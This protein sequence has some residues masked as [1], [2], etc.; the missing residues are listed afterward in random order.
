MRNASI[1]AI[2]SEKRVLRYILAA[3]DFG[4]VMNSARSF[5]L[6]HAP[7]IVPAAAAVLKNFVPASMSGA[8]DSASKLFLTSVLPNLGQRRTTAVSSDGVNQ[9]AI[10]ALLAPEYIQ[11]RFPNSTGIQSKCALGHGKFV[12][13]LVTNSQGNCVLNL[14]IRA[15]GSPQFG[16]L[17][18][19]PTLVLTSGSQAV[20][21]PAI[22]GP[23]TNSPVIDVGFCVSASVVI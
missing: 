19:D 14:N 10:A 15:L 2:E 23:F 6:K 12:I 1:P 18:N 22:L 9:R 7:S 13:N 3:D 17:L 16:F 20:A 8:V 11:E 5:F 4:S 21:A